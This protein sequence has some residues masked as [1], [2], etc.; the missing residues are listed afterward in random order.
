VGRKAARAWSILCGG[1]GV[2]F[3]DALKQREDLERE[4]EL[5]GSSRPALERPRG[6][7]RQGPSEPRST[8]L[9]T[10]QRGLA[11]V[12]K[13]GKR[14]G[15]PSVGQRKCPA[16]PARSPASAP[17]PQKPCLFRRSHRQRRWGY[18]LRPCP[19]QPSGHQ[20]CGAH[21]MIH[22]QRATLCRPVSADGSLTP[23]T[24]LW[25]RIVF[26][27]AIGVVLA[28]RRCSCRPAPRGQGRAKAPRRPATLPPTFRRG[29]STS[30]IVTARGRSKCC[31]RL[32]RAT[33]PTR[34]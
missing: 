27:L 7:V 1:G 8:P 17:R 15:A 34:T 10:Q 30:S 6:P 29:P 21:P 19:L 18:G 26:T 20:S 28:G 14:G 5:R 32:P 24:V 2:A 33:G 12:G 4:E 13:R 23:W 31:P 11:P 9:V 25:K 22:D 16:R 3:L